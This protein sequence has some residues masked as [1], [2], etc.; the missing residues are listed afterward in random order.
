M[1][2]DR[3]SDGRVEK[4]VQKEPETLRGNA[5]NK[6]KALRETGAKRTS[7]SGWTLLAWAVL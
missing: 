1:A 4:G 6:R 3:R 2:Q 5:V 7:E